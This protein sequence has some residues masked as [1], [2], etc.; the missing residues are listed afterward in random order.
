M[1]RPDARRPGPRV[2]WCISRGALTLEQLVGERQSQKQAVDTRRF[3]QTTSPGRFFIDKKIRVHAKQ[4]G[5]RLHDR[6][7]VFKSASASTLL[8]SFA[9]ISAS[10]VRVQR[11]CS[12]E[13]VFRSSRSCRSASKLSGADPVKLLISHRQ[14]IANS[15]LLAPETAAK[16]A[17][18]RPQ[19]PSGVTKGGVAVAPGRG[20]ELGAGIPC[21]THGWKQGLI[22]GRLNDR[23]EPAMSSGGKIIRI[24]GD[25]NPARGM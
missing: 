14:V 18:L 25:N 1:G 16:G 6:E 20:D 10:T 13:T 2:G 22:R 24:A 7:R 17:N 23:A 12:T 11:L 8:S 21:R 15:G 9:A 5:A 19:P 4:I 3:A